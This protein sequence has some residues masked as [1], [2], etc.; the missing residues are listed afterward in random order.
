[1]KAVTLT[2]MLLLASAA[3]AP[4]QTPRTSKDYVKRAAAR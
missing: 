2:L 4:A 3:S 1:M